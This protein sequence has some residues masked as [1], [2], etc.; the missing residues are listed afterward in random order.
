MAI[1][2]RITGALT[3]TATPRPTAARI[4][5]AFVPVMIPV[6]RIV[7]GVL[8]F[9]FLV[10]V[11]CPLL[12]VVPISL[13]VVIM[14]LVSVLSPATV[15]VVV[16][17]VLVVTAVIIVV[18][19]VIVIMLAVIRLLSALVLV[20]VVCIVPRLVLCVLSAGLKGLRIATG[21]SPACGMAFWRISTAPLVGGRV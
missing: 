7:A 17:V 3:P 4:P 19:L 18:P 16:V 2:I 1:P 8:G 12:V 9:I 11:V 14:R 20:L 13:L 6:L 5:H 10:V 21:G 15:A